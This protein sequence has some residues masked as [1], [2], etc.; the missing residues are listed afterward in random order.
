MGAH[1]IVIALVWSLAGCSQHQPIPNTVSN[2][3]SHAVVNSRLPDTVLSGTDVY[4]VSWETSSPPIKLRPRSTKLFLE[5]LARPSVHT[6]I[7]SMPA[8][9]MGSFK[10]GGVEYLW[11]GNGVIRGTGSEKRM[12]QGPFTQRLI[13]EVAKEGYAPQTIPSILNTIEEDP[14]VADTTVSGPGA[15]PGGSDALHPL[16][17]TQFKTIKPAGS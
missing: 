14:S 13:E 15:Y 12:W 1:L 16:P 5:M 11:H 7:S 3:D 9:P 17:A 8:L 10:V 6:E 4:F 2:R